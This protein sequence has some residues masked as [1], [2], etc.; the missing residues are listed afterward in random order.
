MRSFPVLNLIFQANRSW[1]GEF[2]DMKI[3]NLQWLVCSII[4]WRVSSIEDDWIFGWLSRLASLILILCSPFPLWTNGAAPR[5]M[6]SFDARG[7]GNDVRRLV[8]WEF[9][10]RNDSAS[11]KSFESFIQSIS[12]CKSSIMS[13]SSKI[14]SWS[15]TNLRLAIVSNVEHSNF[16][17]FSISLRLMMSFMKKLLISSL[18]FFNLSAVKF[19][20]GWDSIISHNFRAFLRSESAWNSCFLIS[21]WHSARICSLYRSERVLMCACSVF[22]SLPFPQQVTPFGL[23]RV[24][25][26]ARTRTMTFDRQIRCALWLQTRRHRNPRGTIVRGEKMTI[27]WISKKNPCT[28]ICQIYRCRTSCRSVSPRTCDPSFLVDVAVPFLFVIVNSNWHDYCLLHIA[29]HVIWS[30]V[31]TDCSTWV[32]HFYHLSF[33]N[34]L[35][36]CSSTRRCIHEHFLLNLQPF[37]G[38]I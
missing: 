27:T 1:C 13:V 4:L 26:F 8:T 24:A 15:S 23:Q 17:N 7:G 22:G 21:A 6:N 16:L 37:L 19:F 28:F 29:K 25:S 30:V 20:F 35:L 9:P 18:K 3:W 32:L 11:W 12:F 38:W 5:S 14:V 10:L 33:W 2:V 36:G 34:D 31:F